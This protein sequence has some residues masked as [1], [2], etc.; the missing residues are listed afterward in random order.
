M[1]K[2]YSNYEKAELSSIQ[3]RE[4]KNGNKYATG[5][6]IIR[7][8]EGKFQASLRFISWD[9]VGSLQVLADS[10]SVEQLTGGDLPPIEIDGKRADSQARRPRASVTGWFESNRDKDGNWKPLQYVV[11]TVTIL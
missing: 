4:A 7:T 3:I 8:D 5:A 6:I 2:M 11:E 9:A 1:S 10:E